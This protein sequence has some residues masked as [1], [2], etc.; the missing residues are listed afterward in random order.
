MQ[1]GS[2]QTAGLFYFHNKFINMKL[3]KIVMFLTLC[4]LTL[5]LLYCFCHFVL[6][7]SHPIYLDCGKIVS[8]SSDE[9]AIKSGSRTKLYLNVQFEKSGFRSIECNP[10][11]YFSK[12][13]GERSCFYLDKNMGEK[14]HLNNF[15][16][17]FVAMIL[18]ILAFMLL[19][20]YIAPDSFW[21]H[22]DR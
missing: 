13:V 17:M 14:Y 6:T 12:N 1:C 20:N 18:L 7:K 15:I 19:V 11:T 22:N 10:T 3:K 4:P 21:T 9:V 2:A 16:G 8:K 5:Y